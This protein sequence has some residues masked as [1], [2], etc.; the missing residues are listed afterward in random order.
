MLPGSPSNYLDSEDHLEHRILLLAIG[1]G[2]LRSR[3]VADILGADLSHVSAT[4]NRLTEL[5]V[6]TTL[7]EDGEDVFHAQ[8]GPALSAAF[9]S[10]AVIPLG[11]QFNLL[12]DS[13]RLAIFA[14][15]IDR[16]VNPDAMVLDLGC[17][18]AVLA[19]LAAG[20]G[21]Q[22]TAVEMDPMVFNAAQHF[23]NTYAPDKRVRL[24][25]ADALSLNPRQDK[26]DIVI[27]EMLDTGLISEFQVPVM[28]HAVK[29]LL[30]PEGI[31][32]PAGAVCTVSLAKVDFS[33]IVGFD[34]PLPHF[35]RSDTQRIRQILSN[36]VVYA[37]ISFTALNPHNVDTEIIVRTDDDGIVNAILVETETIVAPGLVTSGS[38]WL[39]PPL[40][41]PVND[42]K[43]SNG[44]TFV[45]HL[46]YL[47]GGGLASLSYDLK[48]MR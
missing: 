28:S 17:G 42:I 22:V 7:S 43:V 6:L 48:P 46:S 1:S 27:C 38:Q 5:G 39:N 2:R 34:F 29:T 41:L 35:E 20:K 4:I 33:T 47:F 3:D 9:P 16:L 36:K 10:A 45:V 32:I 26:F 14:Q 40:I 15:A 21:A 8:R 19:I 30:K 23:V 25:R 12:C 31:A 37:S 44:Q 18:T 24:I 11:Y 13:T